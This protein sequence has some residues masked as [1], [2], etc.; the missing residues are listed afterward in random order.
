[1]GLRS[2]LTGPRLNPRQCP[3]VPVEVDPSHPLALGLIGCFVASQGP[4]D[5]C[6]NSPIV[7][8]LSGGTPP[9]IATSAGPAW[10]Q[11]TG[12][13]ALYAPAAPIFKAG[14]TFTVFWSGVCLGSAVGPFDSLAAGIDYADATE[15][16]PYISYGLDS[17]NSMLART[18]A[19]AVGPSMS[20]GDDFNA[21]AILSTFNAAFTNGV[22]TVY[23][24]GTNTTAITFSAVATLC[25]GGYRGDTTRSPNL[26]TRCAYFFNQDFG[27]TNGQSNLPQMAWLSAEPFAMLRPVV[28]RSY[29]KVAAGGS[30]ALSGSA[31]IAAVA[32]GTLKGAGALTGSASIA[33]TATGTLKGAGV[34]SGTAAIAATATGTLT[35]TAALS[36]SASIA[37][38]STGTL[39]GAGALSGTAALAVTASGTLSNGVGLAGTA[40]I[41]ATATGSLKGAGALSG[42]ATATGT[43][44]GT[45][46]GTGALSGTAAI[47]AT[48]TGTLTG[49]GRLI[50]TAAPAVVASGTLTG[51]QTLVGTAAIAAAASGTLRGIG[52]LVG[53][54]AIA[55]TASGNLA[56]PWDFTWPP[57]GGATRPIDFV[58]PPAAPAVLPLDFIWPPE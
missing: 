38:T 19:S 8:T 23:A 5:L 24:N 27:S 9:L 15:V 57:S 49:T 14:Q 18:P 39:T 52:A 6:G 34:L 33:V 17:S 26:A 13:Q 16:S 7:T 44:T 29:Y 4:R 53:G 58:W 1:M 2:F 25:I 32:T 20:V 48:A 12:A 35:G 45:L 54:S 56:T 37:A 28:R 22:P 55:V 43:A 51:G 36:G 21:A 46:T 3:T 42:S 47:A 41:A 50:G 10:Q 30:G 31:A 40:A 11:T